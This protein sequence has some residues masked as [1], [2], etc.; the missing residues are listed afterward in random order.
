MTADDNLFVKNLRVDANVGVQEV[1]RDNSQP[2]LFSLRL[3]TE[4]SKAAA[5]GELEDS[6]DYY[7]V[8]RWLADYVAEKKWKLL[9]TLAEEVCRQCLGKFSV[10]EIDLTIEKPKAIENAET[11]GIQIT[12]SISDY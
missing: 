7:R 1:E 11:A 10:D 2:L 9:E 4:I 12:R 5:A 6:V 8:S 3:Y